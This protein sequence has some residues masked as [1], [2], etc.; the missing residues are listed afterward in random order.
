MSDDP[1]GLGVNGGDPE[2]QKK[3]PAGLLTAAQ[4]EKRLR[5]LVEG[6]G[7]LVE[8]LGDPYC[9]YVLQKRAEP[10]AGAYARLASRNPTWRRMLS[11]L[12]T[13]SEL[14]EAL[15]LTAGTAFPILAHHGWVP[16]GIAGVFMF[17]LT[18]PSEEVAAAEAKRADRPAAGYPQ[19]E[20]EPEEPASGDGPGSTG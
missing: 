20:P 12:L 9:G 7:E 11:G 15:M 2:K 5:E 17:G 16:E 3:K 18:P 6:A 14:A 4:I 19:P 1:I 10:L 8:E 13:T